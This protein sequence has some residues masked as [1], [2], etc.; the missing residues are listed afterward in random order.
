M[1]NKVSQRRVYVLLLSDRV[2]DE[3]LSEYNEQ[4]DEHSDTATSRIR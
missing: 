4:G 3:E 1:G 2:R